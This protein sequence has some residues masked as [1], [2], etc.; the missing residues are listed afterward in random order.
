MSRF[1]SSNKTPAV[2]DPSSSSDLFKVHPVALTTW[3]LESWFYSTHLELVLAL[4]PIFLHIAP[5]TVSQKP[6]PVMDSSEITAAWPNG[7]H[8]SGWEAAGR[9]QA[10][11]Q[12]ESRTTEE[13]RKAAGCL[14]SYRAAAAL[15]SNGSSLDHPHGQAV[16]SFRVQHDPLLAR[17]GHCMSREMLANKAV[18]KPGRV[19]SHQ[20]CSF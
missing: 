9:N 18:P 8:Q 17:P 19:S 15:S 6:R 12:Q 16:E 2:T 1:S 5:D 10:G 20:L 3:H 4:G 7:G 11:V 13:P 14:R